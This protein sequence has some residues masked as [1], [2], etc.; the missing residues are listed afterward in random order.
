[1]F[2]LVP[3]QQVSGTCQ[4]HFCP[5]LSLPKVPRKYFELSPNTLPFL[6][7]RFRKEDLTPTPNLLRIRPIPPPLGHILSA[8]NLVELIRIDN[9]TAKTYVTSSH[10]VGFVDI[11]ALYKVYMTREVN[12]SDRTFNGFWKSLASKMYAQPAKIHNLMLSVKG[13]I[14]Q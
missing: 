12:S 11:L 10:K 8:L 3:C 2:L 7:L 14:R 5:V 4:S 13:C 6:T 9:K 1:M